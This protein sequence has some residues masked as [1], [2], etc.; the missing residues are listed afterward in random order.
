MNNKNRPSQLKK[1]F[2]SERLRNS[3]LFP[4]DREEIIQYAKAIGIQRYNP[5]SKLYTNNIIQLSKL[6]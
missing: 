3:F 5:Y 4:I 6:N 2:A 1:Q